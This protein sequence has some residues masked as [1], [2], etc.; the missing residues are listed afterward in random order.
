MLPHLPSHGGSQNGSPDMR[1]AASNLSLGSQNG[2]GI[3]GGAT[4]GVGG[5]D[6]GGGKKFSDGHH[7]P[8]IWHNHSQGSMVH[9]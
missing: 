4:Q 2:I 8:T 1:L 9:A 3:S 7:L 5:R 6:M